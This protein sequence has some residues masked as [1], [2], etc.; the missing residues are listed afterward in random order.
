MHGFVAV[1]ALSLGGKPPAAAMREGGGAVLAGDARQ[2][3]TTSFPHRRRRRLTDHPLGW[4][5][6]AERIY[7]WLSVIV[8]RQAHILKGAFC[9]MILRAKSSG[10]KRL[11][12]CELAS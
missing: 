8:M 1:F 2:R 9:Q 12:E 10:K 5:A 7:E 11:S 6:L 4:E 3:R